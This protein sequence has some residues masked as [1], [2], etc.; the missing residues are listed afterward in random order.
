MVN[1]RGLRDLEGLGV[2][3]GWVAC[4]TMEQGW[5]RVGFEEPRACSM[6]G[7][8]EALSHLHQ[9]LIGPLYDTQG[10]RLTDKKLVPRDLLT[11]INTL[12]GGVRI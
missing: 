7:R 6:L 3:S 1:V 12:R 8:S 5:W 10:N 2:A 9:I 4:V 11:N